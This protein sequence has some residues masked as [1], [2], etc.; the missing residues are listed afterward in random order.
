M[1]KGDQ[2]CSRGATAKVRYEDYECRDQD[3]T[4]GPVYDWQAEGEDSAPETRALMD[5]V[6]LAMCYLRAIPADVFDR[7]YFGGP[8]TSRCL[9]ENSQRLRDDKKLS[10][11][12]SP[13]TRLCCIQSDAMWPLRATGA[14]QNSRL[15]AGKE[16]RWSCGL[17][18]VTADRSPLPRVRAGLKPSVLPRLLGQVF[19]REVDEEEEE[20]LLF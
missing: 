2:R 12:L 19:F 16:A 14:R 6:P 7:G 18:A 11:F 8:R 4:N 3:G 13:M 15:R 10:S 1:A 5:D 20:D 17:P 9:P